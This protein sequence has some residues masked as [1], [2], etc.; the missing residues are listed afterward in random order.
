MT[1]DQNEATLPTRPRQKEDRL[2][3]VQRGKLHGLEHID[4]SGV[5]HGRAKRGARAR[6]HPGRIDLAGVMAEIQTTPLL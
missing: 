5:Q 4:D 2:C 3:D 1:E 6:N